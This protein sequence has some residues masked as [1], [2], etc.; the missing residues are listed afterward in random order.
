M[1]LI[2]FLILLVVVVIWSI[3]KI[4]SNTIRKNT[5]D[6]NNK[7]DKE[8]MST[9]NFTTAKNVTSQI[10]E[11]LKKNNI[12][13]W[14]SEDSKTFRVGFDLEH[15]GKYEMFINLF[16]D[17]IAFTCGVI[18]DVSDEAVSKT[19]E[20]VTRINQ[21]YNFGH[22]EFYYESRVVAFKNE[23]IL[24]E[25]ELTE[26]K[27]RMYFDLT[28][29]GSKDCRSLVSKVVNDGEEP[30]IAMMNLGNNK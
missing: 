18:E 12:R 15:H 11:Y 8:K 30:V 21:F 14:L 16:N 20:I 10:S 27:F 29:E 7:T 28:L 26:N 2:A 23:Y 4:D 1:E 24:F 6:Q 3:K 22:L 9:P 19:A 13:F 25:N 17:Y 5:I